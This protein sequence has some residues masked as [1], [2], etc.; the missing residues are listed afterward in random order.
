MWILGYCGGSET[1][2]PESP[3]TA[4]RGGLVALGGR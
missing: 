2:E 1:A 4:L 3:G